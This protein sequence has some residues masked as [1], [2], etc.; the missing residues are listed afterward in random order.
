MRLILLPKD[1]TDSSLFFSPLLFVDL[2]INFSLSPK[3]CLFIISYRGEAG[4]YKPR[5]LLKY[6][7]YY[8][9]PIGISISA[10]YCLI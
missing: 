8:A 6:S 10:D 3:H 4:G 9:H 1:E 2:K 5:F 7:I